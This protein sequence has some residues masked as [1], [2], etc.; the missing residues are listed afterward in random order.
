MKNSAPVNYAKLDHTSYRHHQRYKRFINSMPHKLIC[1]ECGGAGG[2]IVP[3][4]DYGQGPLE[5]CGF[6]EGTG[7]LTPWLR[8]Q[9]LTFKRQEK[10]RIVK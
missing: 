3:V 8:G 7:Y 6:C 1:Q 9:W 5:E 4:L 10:H 2:E